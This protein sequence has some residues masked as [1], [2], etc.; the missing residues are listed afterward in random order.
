[1]CILVMGSGRAPN[2]CSAT[3]KIIRPIIRPELLT[4][5]NAE[6][7]KY[8]LLSRHQNAGQNQDIKISNRCLENVAQFEYCIWERL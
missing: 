6:K 4:L 8:M 1:M 3:E 5:V 7:Y 2:G